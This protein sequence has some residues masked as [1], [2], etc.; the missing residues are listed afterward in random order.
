M[1]EEILK[2][3]DVSFIDEATLESVQEMMVKDYQQKYEEVTKKSYILPRADPMALILYACSVQIF[4]ALLYV[5]R[6]GKQNLMK[7]AYSDFVDHIAALRGIKR[8]GAKA[9]RTTIRFTLSA[10][11]KEPV[12][13]PAGARVTNGQEIY[14]ATQQYAEISPGN[15]TIDLECVCLKTGIVGNDFLPGEINTLTDPIGYMEKAENINVS[16]GGTDIE[17]DESV[18]ERTYFAPSSYSV[19]GP[20]DAYVYWAKT[21]NTNITDVKITSPDPVEVVVTFI[22]QGGELPEDSLVEGLENYLKDKS[23]RPLTDLV[24]V[25]KPELENYTINVKYY[26][27]KSDSYKA[28]SIQNEVNTAVNDFII[29]QSSKIGR[30]INPSVLIE[31]MIAAGAKR[32]EVTQPIF[33]KIQDTAVAKLG[34]Q[35]VSY[36]GIEDD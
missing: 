11:R 6:G 30:D 18:I 1:I 28:L 32:V 3:S 25:K 35:S 7:Y 19:A 15:T 29:W 31:K 17:S 36:G 21:Y 34:S 10:A 9:A 16:D 24:T 20:D 33:K 12:A 23:I 13:I 22:L 8:N 27:N 26:I 5:D 14:F 2:L 4:Q